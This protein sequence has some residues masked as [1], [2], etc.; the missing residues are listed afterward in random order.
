MSI[1]PRKEEHYDDYQVKPHS[2]N[3]HEL[4]SNPSISQYLEADSPTKNIIANH[5]KEEDDSF[6]VF[7]QVEKK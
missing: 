3:Q 1:D 6:L 2:K 7:K 4:I 5:N